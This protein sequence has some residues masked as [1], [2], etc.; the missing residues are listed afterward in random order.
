[1]SIIFSKDHETWNTRFNTLDMKLACQMVRSE[2]PVNR[3]GSNNKF[4]HF[5]DPIPEDAHTSNTFEECCM[6]SAADMW[7]LAAG[8]E[9]VLFWSGG[10]DSTSAAIALLATKRDGK[11]TIRCTP[12]SIEEFPEYYE[13]IKDWCHLVTDTEFLDVDLFG[14]HTKLKITGECGDQIFGSDALHSKLDIINQ[15]WQTAYDWSA[16]YIFPGYAAKQHIYDRLKGDFFSFLVE[17]NSYCPFEIRTIFDMYWWLNFTT[18]WMDV[19][20]RMIFIYSKC[21]HWQ[22]TNSFFNTPAFQQWSLSNHDIKHENSWETYKQP[23]KEYIHKHFKNENYRKNKVKLPSL[24]NVIQGKK[25]I[26][27]KSIKL[28]LSDGRTWYKDDPLTD[29]EFID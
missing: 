12:T 29:D 18:K 20:R 5:F 3:T 19:Q 23:A 26:D 15:P 25:V 17:H 24:I 27:S 11:L 16:D 2:Y 14:D 7:D 22:S 10:I 9:V 21:D 28:C 8:R 1:M 13:H 6:A 4:N